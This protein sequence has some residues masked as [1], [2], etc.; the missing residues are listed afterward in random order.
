MKKIKLTKEQQE[1]F[2][3]L[4]DAETFG[5]DVEIIGGMLIWKGGIWRRGVF[6]RGY[7]EDGL[8]ESGDWL[9][10]RMWCNLTQRFV[11]VKWNK[12]EGIFEQIS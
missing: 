1:E 12:E 3:W 2:K 10:G 11:N 6:E 9:S 4:M 8:W 5:E 7:W